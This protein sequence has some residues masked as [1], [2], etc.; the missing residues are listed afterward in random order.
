MSR[1]GS[2]FDKSYTLR[3]LSDDVLDTLYDTEIKFYGWIRRVRVGGGGSLVFIDIY[4]GTKVGCLRGVASSDHYINSD[5]YKSDDNDEKLYKTLVYSDLSESSKLS[6]GCAV[7]V[8]GI[9]VKS[10]EGTTQ[11]FELQIKKLQ[12]IGGIEIIKHIQYKN[13]VKKVC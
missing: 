6:C 3:E 8:E 4:D 5:E 13:Q 2:N 9:L 12:I 1:F 7:A 10:P 11:K